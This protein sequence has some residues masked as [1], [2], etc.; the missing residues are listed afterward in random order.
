MK[1]GLPLLHGPFSKVSPLE[2]SYRLLAG[3]LQLPSRTATWRTSFS[4]KLQLAGLCWKRQLPHPDTVNLSRDSHRSGE[5]T[6]WLLHFQHSHVCVYIVWQNSFTFSGLKGIS[7]AMHL[8][9]CSWMSLLFHPVFVLD[10]ASSSSD[11]QCWEGSCPIH[12]WQAFPI[13]FC[14]FYYL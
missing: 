14:D 2:I 4:P 8:I 1:L 6:V 12:S 9:T 7:L 11:E 3:S 13:F 5:S 10:L